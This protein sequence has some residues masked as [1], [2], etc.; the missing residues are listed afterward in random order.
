MFDL[1]TSQLTL[2]LPSRTDVVQFTIKVDGVQ[3][4]DVMEV[5]SIQ[6]ERSFNRISYATIKL[7]DGD[8]STQSFDTSDQDILSPGKEIEIKVGY[9]PNEDTLF[10]GIIIRHALKILPDR[11]PMVEIEC[12]DKAVKL[13]VKRKN[14]YFFEQTDAQ[15]IESLA[16]SAGLTTDVEDSSVNHAELVQYHTTDWDF[17]MLRAEAN[18]QLVLTKD[19]E[20]IIKKPNL[21]Q[22]EKFTVTYGSSLY[23]FEAEMDARDQY[24]GATATTWSVESQDVLAI[25]ASASGASSVGGLGG[26]LASAVSGA[27]TAAGGALGANLPGIPPN[28]DYTSVIS[29]DDYEI[30][31]SGNLTQEELQ[32]W[33]EAQFQKSILAQKKGRVRF[34]GIADIYPGDMISLQGVGQRHQGKVFVSAVRHEVFEGTWFTHAQFGMSHRWFHQEFQDIAAPAASGLVPAIHGLQIGVVTKLA[35]DPDNEFRIQVKLPIIDAASDGIWARI[36]LQDAGDNRSA[37]FLPEV[38][39]EVIVGFINDDPRD[40]IV[41]GALHSSAKPAPITAAD[42]NHEKGWWTRS[43][44]KMLFND[45]DNNRNLSIETPDGKKIIVHDSNDILQLEDQHGN[46]IVMD[47][48]G[49]TIESAG[50]LNITAQ[51]D[52]TIEGMNV[53]ISA[54]SNFQAEGS[55]R[56]ELTSTGEVVVNGGVVRIN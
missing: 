3:I 40:A 16:Q 30:R 13:S 44:I 34:Q 12:K 24:P 11:R 50:T 4:P 47:A 19:G 7:L 1:N 41:V 31:H 53:S 15:V 18:G 28:T 36:A 52:I 54:N 38:G 32:K 2:P 37:F 9:L 49:I 21:N 17:L 55:T 23:E 43:G 27:V 10:K 35:P 46:K 56:A 14:Q 29:D 6:V 5:F 8:A 22:T 48:N 45:D 51:Q 25:Q 39:D 26:G 42:E 33:A 20:L